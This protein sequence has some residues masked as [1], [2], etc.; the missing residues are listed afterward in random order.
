MREPAGGPIRG[1]DHAVPVANPTHDG[2]KR[3]GPGGR[4][5]AFWLEHPHA[6]RSGGGRPTGARV[7]HRLKVGIGIVVSALGVWLSMRDV[8][9][10]EVWAALRHANY[11]GFIA[12][13]LLTLLAFLVR[14]I[15]WR[16]LISTPRPL[17]YYNLFSATMIG[18]MANNMLPLRLGEFVRAWALA[19]REK[20]SKTTVLAT[21]I[22]ER[23]VDMLTLL[24][25]LGIALLVH[26]IAQGSRAWDLTRKGAMA[27]VTLSMALTVFVVFLE[28]KPDLMRALIGKIAARLPQGVGEKGVK[29]LEHFV[30]GLGLFRDL[31]RVL[32]V[33]LLSFVMF[34]IVVVGL[35]VSM[36]SLGIHLPWYAGLTMLVITA[37][38][39]MVPA[40]PGYIGTMN[41]AC[42]A[43]LALFSVGKTSAVPFSWFYWASQW[44]PVTLV[45]FIYLRREGLSL[46][47]LGEAEESAG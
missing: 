45:G 29:A 37:I 26:P 19:R 41:V 12:A 14:A 36:W 4:G 33:F 42:V 34:G 28:H 47:R 9:P 44:L 10:A 39:I 8:R 13:A 5:A 16:S 18:F 25:I 21:V 46:R 1:G 2:A 32:W 27:L 35:Q 11:F 20:L 43:G 23:V 31:P 38:G 40:A 24:A 7:S 3:R 17:S 15:R 6:P 30:A 22:V